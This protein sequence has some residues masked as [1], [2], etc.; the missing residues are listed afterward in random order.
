[1]IVGINLQ[2][3]NCKN[4]NYDDGEKNVIASFFRMRTEKFE[5][6]AKR[7]RYKKIPYS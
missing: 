3:A 4:I 7:G 1:M 6:R 2:T 5:D